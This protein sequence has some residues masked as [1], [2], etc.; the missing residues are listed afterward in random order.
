MP[1][2]VAFYQKGPHRR[3]R[4]LFGCDLSPVGHQVTKSGNGSPSERPQWH[5]NWQSTRWK[6]RRKKLGRNSCP[7][8]TTDMQGYSRKE[9]RRNS[10]TDVLGITPS[11]SEM[12]PPLQSTVG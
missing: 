8:G 5:N 9:I 6:A 3:K 10:L 12:T 11:T 4:P 2:V 7:K 1:I